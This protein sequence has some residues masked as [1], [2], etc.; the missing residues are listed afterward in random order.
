VHLLVFLYKT[1][2][3][4]RYGAHKMLSVLHVCKMTNTNVIHIA[5]KQEFIKEAEIS[6]IR[7]LVTEFLEL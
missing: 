4:A 5:G 1:C 6:C 2:L 7:S 3:N